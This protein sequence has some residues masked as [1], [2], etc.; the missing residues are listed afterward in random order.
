MG[1]TFLTVILLIY[2]LFYNL[3][4]DFKTNFVTTSHT[5]IMY[6]RPI[7]VVKQ[8]YNKKSYPPFFRS[9]K[10][11]KRKRLTVAFTS[12]FGAIL[13]PCLAN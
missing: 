2:E 12:G 1:P 6:G 13:L 10:A 5:G 9:P 3:R 4:R 7:F 8:N 11:N